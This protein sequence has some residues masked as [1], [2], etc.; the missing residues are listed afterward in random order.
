MNNSQPDNIKNTTGKCDKEPENL[1]NMTDNEL[2]YY[3]FQRSDE[4]SFRKRIKEA[5][6]CL[7]YYR[8]NMTSK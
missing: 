7:Q 2:E 4:E 3:Y 8:A 1:I 6:K 5:K